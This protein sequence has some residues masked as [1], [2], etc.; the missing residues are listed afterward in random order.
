[1]RRLTLPRVLHFNVERASVDNKTKKQID[2]LNLLQ[3][4]QNAQESDCLPLKKMFE[5]NKLYIIRK[6]G[7]ETFVLS[8]AILDRKMNTPVSDNRSDD[9]GSSLR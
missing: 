5:N 8:N 2:K 7:V 4:V 3:S 9:R 1:M 6:I